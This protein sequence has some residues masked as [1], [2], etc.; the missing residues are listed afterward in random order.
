MLYA[1]QMQDELGEDLEE[2]INP[3]CQNHSKCVETFRAIATENLTMTQEAKPENAIAD[4][5]SKISKITETAE[6]TKGKPCE[7]CHQNF[8]KKLKRQKRSYQ[9]VVLVEKAPD[10]QN[11][12]QIDVNGLVGTVLEPLANST[13]LTIFLGIYEGKKSFSKLSQ[14]SN[15]KGGHLIFHLKKLL[16]SGLIIQEDNKGDYIITEKGIDVVKKILLFK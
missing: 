12:E 1:K 13:R 6:K 7:K 3:Q 11:N 5:D 8:G 2:I 10:D 4:L 14:I 15:L 16:G 9:T